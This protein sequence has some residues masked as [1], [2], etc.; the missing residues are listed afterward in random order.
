VTIFSF[1][2]TKC[3]TG[4]EGGLAVSRN[5]S[6]L[7]AMRGFRDGFV[8]K[9]CVRLFSPL[10]DLAA[11]LV[12]SQL[13]QYSQALRMRRG[14]ADRYR[15]RFDQVLPGA[16]NRSAMANSMF[17][18]FPVH[19]SGGLDRFQGHFMSHGVHVRRG[20]DQLL[21]RLFGLNDADFPMSIR[22]FGT[23]VSLPIYPGLTPDEESVCMRSVSQVFGSARSE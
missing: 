11:G 4:G 16:L 7:A 14:I 1:H 15:E 21:H 19:V 13:R 6:V 12:L 10:S 22:H 20:V 8:A 17:F 3:I 23:T 5:A 2:P 9:A 18:R